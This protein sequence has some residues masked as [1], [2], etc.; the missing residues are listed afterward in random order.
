MTNEE[1]VEALKEMGE[2]F[3]YMRQHFDAMKEQHNKLVASYNQA[4]QGCEQA[5]GEVALRLCDLDGRVR[6]LET[7]GVEDPPC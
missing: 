7:G 3:G 4:V 5:F 1:I 6:H 2:T